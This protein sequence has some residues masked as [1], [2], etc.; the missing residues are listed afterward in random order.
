MT[1]EILWLLAPVGLL[2]GVGLLVFGMMRDRDTHRRGVDHPVWPFL[3]AGAGFTVALLTEVFMNL[4]WWLYLVPFV[5]AV[6]SLVWA[7]AGHGCNERM[8]RTYEGR[9]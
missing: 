9:P 2:A 6:L 5:G 3:G 1:W 7:Q 4:H 8:R